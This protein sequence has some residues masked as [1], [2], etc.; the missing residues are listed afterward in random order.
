MYIYIYVYVYMY[1]NSYTHTHTQ[2][3]TNT[4]TRTCVHSQVMLSITISIQA[5]NESFQRFSKFQKLLPK[6]LISHYA[7]DRTIDYFIFRCHISHVCS[8]YVQIYMCVL[9]FVVY[10]NL[11][12]LMPASSLPRCELHWYRVCGLCMFVCLCVSV[13]GVCVHACTCVCTRVYVY[14]YVCGRY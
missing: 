11:K 8:M 2:P 5:T 14:V 6:N 10:L 7:L 13:W 1:V 4:R 3:R 9:L 12:I